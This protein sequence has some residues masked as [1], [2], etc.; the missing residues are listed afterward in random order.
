[1]TAF[2]LLL[3]SAGWVELASESPRPTVIVVVG[4]EGTE[5]YGK[6]FREWASRW[7]GA[8]KQGNA[9][10][11]SIGMD[12]DDKTNDLDTLKQQIGRAHV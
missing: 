4:A 1:M 5:E 7:Q 3:C 11:S 6:Q 2:L 9:A 10:F 8:A 12:A